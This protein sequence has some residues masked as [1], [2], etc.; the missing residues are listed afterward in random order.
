MVIKGIVIFSE[1]LLVTLHF[2]PDFE[3][4]TCV[5][6]VY[7]KDVQKECRNAVFESLYLFYHVLREGE[8]PGSFIYI[9]NIREFLE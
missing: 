2:I 6:N 9:G 1:V 3:H 8:I 5:P 4:L 7:S